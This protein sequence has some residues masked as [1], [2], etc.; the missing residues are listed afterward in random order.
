[1]ALPRNTQL[2]PHVVAAFS[3]TRADDGAPGIP[4]EGQSDRTPWDIFEETF[5]AQNP[6]TAGEEN[7]EPSDDSSVSVSAMFRGNK[8]FGASMNL[9]ACFVSMWFS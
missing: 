7:V 4:T 8:R 5:G 6:L 3:Y 1:M 9:Y 2:P